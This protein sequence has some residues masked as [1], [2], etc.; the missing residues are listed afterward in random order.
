[1]L[2]IRCRL[3]HRPRVA[4]IWI[5]GR[6]VRVDYRWAAGKADPFIDRWRNLRPL[7]PTS[8]WPREQAYRQFCKPRAPFQSW[9]V[10]VADPVGNSYVASEP[11]AAR[12]QRHWLFV[13][14]IHSCCEMG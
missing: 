3:R 6:D 13:F 5:E 4:L 14:R 2:K 8:S 12:R 10:R 7:R 9:F 11:V 1:M